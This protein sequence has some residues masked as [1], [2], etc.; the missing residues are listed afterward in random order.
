VGGGQQRAGVLPTPC[1]CPARGGNPAGG[2]VPETNTKHLVY[3]DADGHLHDLAWAPGSGMP[4]RTDITAASLAPGAADDP[5]FVA[6]PGSTTSRV[7]Y[8]GIDHQIHEI[9]WN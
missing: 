9:R 5:V 4:A 3:R 7:V 1:G 2:Y 6:L 8:R